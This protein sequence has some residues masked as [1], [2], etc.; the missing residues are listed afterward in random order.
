MPE[1]ELAASFYQQTRIFEEEMEQLE[2]LP[3]CQWLINEGHECGAVGYVRVETGPVTYDVPRTTY[4]LC[5]P[6]AIYE[7]AHS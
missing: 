2:T 5:L 4:Q 1:S 6:H 3:L 7:M